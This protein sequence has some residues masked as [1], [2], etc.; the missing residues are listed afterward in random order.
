MRRSCSK[1]RKRGRT[2]GP[3]F[4]FSAS[5][6]PA[7]GLPMGRTCGEC[8][9]T[10]R[11]CRR[12]IAAVKRNGGIYRGRAAEKACVERQ[13]LIFNRRTL[14]SAGDLCCCK[15]ASQLLVDCWDLR[16]M[17][18]FVLTKLIVGAA[19]DNRA[20]PVAS[21]VEGVAAKYKRQ[22]SSELHGGLA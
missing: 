12:R 22:T 21:T 8:G 2:C 18:Y 6:N 4:S 16:P 5:R 17:R 3:S 13:Y 20:R 10:K 15:V 19:A 11:V 14:R 9:W 1:S 7:T